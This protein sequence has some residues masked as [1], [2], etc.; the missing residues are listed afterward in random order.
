MQTRMCP[1]DLAWEQPEEISD[2]W[3]IQFLEVDTL[4]PIA[5]FVLVYNRGVATEF[6]I[7]SKGS[8]NI[9]LRLKYRNSATVIRLS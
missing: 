4:R 5:D 8:Y 1:D 3:L 9:S 2:N 6:G 7:L